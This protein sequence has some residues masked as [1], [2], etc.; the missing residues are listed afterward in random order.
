MGDAKKLVRRGLQAVSTGG[1]SEFKEGRAGDQLSKA[2]EKPFKTGASAATRTAG[3]QIAKQKQ[4]ENLKL[5]ETEDEIAR[6]KALASGGRGGR[7]SLIKS[8]PAGLATTLGGT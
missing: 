3:Q 2:I 5:L 6:R 1:L 7:Q 8:S 4:V